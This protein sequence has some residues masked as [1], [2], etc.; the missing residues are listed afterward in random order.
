MEKIYGIKNG[1][2]GFY[3]NQYKELGNNFVAPK[4]QQ[5]LANEL[6]IEVRTIQN[7]KK[8]TQLIPEITDLVDTGIVTPTTAISIVIYPQQKNEFGH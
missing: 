1:G 5:D 3:G 2:S 7:Y 4:T 6:G 8:L